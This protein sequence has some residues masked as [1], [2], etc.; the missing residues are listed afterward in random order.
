MG[1]SSDE[2]DGG[3]KFITW[4]TMFGDSVA[5][6]AVILVVMVVVVEKQREEASE[7]KS[8]PRPN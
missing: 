8:T 7:Q 5:G 2:S 1:W 4:Y 6:A 3:G